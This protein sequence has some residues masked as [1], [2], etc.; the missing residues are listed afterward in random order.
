MR[1]AELRTWQLSNRNFVLV[2]GSAFGFL[3][4]GPFT[5]CKKTTVL[6]SAA[7]YLRKKVTTTIAELIIRSNFVPAQVPHHLW[8]VGRCVRVL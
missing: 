8:T 7:D 3:E 6:R 4:T 2:P 1:F 5:V